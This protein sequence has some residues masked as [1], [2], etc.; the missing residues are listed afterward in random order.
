MQPDPTTCSRARFARDPRF[1]GRFFIA[2][3][4][5]RI[6]CRPICP[7]RPPKEENVRYYATAAAAAEAGFRPCLRCRPECSPGTP[8]WLGTSAT[9]SRALRLISESALE[10]A[11]ID[12][13]A[14]R[15]GIGSRH[16]RRLFLQH[17]GAT[18]IAIA[19]TRRLHFAK[20][21]ID[22]THLPMSQI[23]LASGFGSVRRFNATFQKTYGRTPTHIR[24]LARHA[25]AEEEDEYRFLLRFRPPLDWNGLLEFLG[26]RA[27]PGVEV[28]NDDSYR[29]TFQ[30]D[31]Q[32]GW[33]EAAL[34]ADASSLALR[35]HFPDPRSLFLIVERVR[36]LFDL[37]A[38]P[39][40]ITPHLRRDPL[41]ARRIAARPGLRVPGAWDGFELAIRAILG[42]Q[43]TVRGAST[44]AGRLVREFGTPVSGNHGLTHIFPTAEKLADVDVA[45]I[46]L[47]RARANTIRALARAVMKGDIEFSATDVD[48]FR[49]RLCALPGIGDWT[50]QYIAM[51]ALGEPDAFPASDL[52][53]LHATGIR[54]PRELQARAEAWRPW[55]AY[56]AMHLWQGKAPRPSPARQRRYALA[57]QSAGGA[58]QLGPALQGW[59]RDRST[60]KSRRDDQRSQAKRNHPSRAATPFISPPR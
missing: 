3:L 17:L 5:T 33:L 36:R 23:A 46:G 34:D 31:K 18:P 29:R 25:P 14:A 56:A 59:V 50:A 28:I 15:V 16:L 41:L 38:D 37:S 12:S 26:P 2:V 10:D 27:I 52:G 22:E 9:V 40:E 48:A 43:V 30:L 35:I 39:A 44:L 55:R 7:A 49:E 47:P 8:A 4:T 6:Y 42:Q 57:R 32:T 60:D 13:L 21:L 19:Q 11:S 53:L 45:R 24:T 58:P 51:R 1:D 54:N 20:K